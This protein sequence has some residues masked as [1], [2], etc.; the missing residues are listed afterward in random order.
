MAEPNLDLND[1]Q[2][3]TLFEKI[4][5]NGNGKIEKQEMIIFISNILDEQANLVLKVDLTV[6]MSAL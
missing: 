6:D 5:T 3:A 4:D 1:D 2:L